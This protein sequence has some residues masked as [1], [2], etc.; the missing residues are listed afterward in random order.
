VFAVC[1]VVFVLSLGLL[2]L[3]LEPIRRFLFQV[4]SASRR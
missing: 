4:G 1:S 2:M 3:G